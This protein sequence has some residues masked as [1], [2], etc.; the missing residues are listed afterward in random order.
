MTS[1]ITR[2]KVLISGTALALATPMV[3][4]AQEAKAP[5]KFGVALPLTGPAAPGGAD[6]VQSLE[7]SVA[8]I[9][10]AGGA[11]GRMLELVAADTQAKPQ[12]GVDAVTR[13]ISLEK[14]PLIVTAYSAVVAAV[15][16]I[17]NRAEVLALVAGANSPRIAEMGEYVYTTYP[18]AD[19]DL[20]LLAKYTREEMKMKKAAIIFI[21]DESGKFGAQVFRDTFTSL[22]GEVV[23]FDSYEPGATDYTGAL[24]KIKAANPD[25]VHLQG[26][27]GDSP[28]VMQQL[29]QLRIEVPVTSYNAAYSP[30]L[31][32]QVGPAADGLIVASLSPGVSDNPNVQPFIDR[33]KSEMGREPNL[34]AANQVVSDTAYIVKALV[35][36]LDNAGQELTGKNLRQALL[37]IGDFKQPLSGD[38]HIDDTHRVVKPVYLLEVKNSKFEPLAKFR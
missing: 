25:F 29:R 14:V 28:Q 10:A 16:P 33:W 19:V 9:N 6:Q 30:Q 12:V 20:T 26:N 1:E 35:E 15:A 8:E 21:N 23:A 4:R 32:N 38:V 5:F 3:V 7:W 13:L 31:I 17:V 34:L 27:A 37:D 24:L 11:G 2:R 36:H 22:G 18:L